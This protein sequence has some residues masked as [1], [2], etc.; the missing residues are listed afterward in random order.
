MMPRT[1][2]SNDPEATRDLAREIAADVAAPVVI[3]LYGDL[4]AGKTLFTQ[5]LAR[6]LGVTAPV[7]SPTFTL[8]NEYD[9]SDGG[10]VFHV[11]VY[12]LHDALAEAS[13][14]GLEELFDEGIVIIEWAGRIQPLLPPRRLDIYIEH[15]GENVRRFTI[16]DDRKSDEA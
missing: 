1:I 14:L 5:A 15:V 9:L 6:A 10:K 8:V 12:R 13:A 4:G 3:A 2:L 11:D 7:T 16:Y